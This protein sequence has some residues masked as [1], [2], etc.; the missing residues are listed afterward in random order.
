MELGTYKKLGYEGM[1]FGAKNL[2]FCAV[3][4]CGISGYES[5]YEKYYKTYCKRSKFMITLMNNSI[6]ASI[7]SCGFILASGIV[8]YLQF[9]YK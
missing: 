7:L 3:V 1:K 9:Y 6:W 8:Y 4:I 2:I 5:G